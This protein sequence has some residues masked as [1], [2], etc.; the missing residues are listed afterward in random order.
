MLR[1]ASESGSVKLSLSAVLRVMIADASTAARPEPR[2]R[3]NLIL[4]P[5]ERMGR[6]VVMFLVVLVLLAAVGGLL[7]GAFPPQPQVKPVEKVLPNER[8]QR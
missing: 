2:G 4:N 3:A 7:L 1:P 6:I 8:F 5:R